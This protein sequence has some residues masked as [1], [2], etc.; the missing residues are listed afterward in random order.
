VINRANKFSRKN[1]GKNQNTFISSSEK[2]IFVPIQEKPFLMNPL[3]SLIL[4]ISFAT[5]LVMMTSCKEKNE[6]YPPLNWSEY[7]YT[8][9]GI[10]QREISAIYYENDHSL[11]LGAKGKEGLLHNDGYKWTVYD[12][13]STGI[14]FDSITS[15][16]RD[17]NNNLW[18][19]WKSG[20]A[21]YD[22]NSWN[23][24]VEFSGL[25]ATSLVVEGIGKIRVGIK[26]K[27]G[28]LAT[29]QNNEWHFQTLLNSDILSGNIN[30]IVSDYNQ[31]LWLA[32]A[33]KGIFQLKN[34]EWESISN[35]LPLSSKNFSSIAK[36][37][38]GSI[39]AGSQAAQ[40]LHFLDDTFTILNTGTSKPITSVV[41]TDD[42]TIWCGTSGAGIV[43]FDGKNWSG[44]TM[45]NSDLPSNEIV[46]LTA[47]SPGYLLFS[48][49]GGKLYLLKQ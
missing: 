35:D 23:E 8:G 36:A 28:G 29:L 22:G 10:P 27:S 44:Y 33:D 38:G 49:S 5:S 21:V 40:L 20:L 12:F 15:I 41:V 34:E 11:W 39:W 31:V 19:G 3:R 9:S 7:S 16:V 32:S 48:V 46:C 1:E 6:E 45:E 43:S 25:M 47:A 30:S 2:G 24:I 17:G 14:D 4:L 42:E 13:A 37:P 18:V 26:G